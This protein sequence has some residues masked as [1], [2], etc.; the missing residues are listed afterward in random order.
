MISRTATLAVA[1]AIPLLLTVLPCQADEQE[2]AIEQC[3]DIDNPELR[4]RC[5]E[6]AI[7][8]LAGDR[9]PAPDTPAEVPAA[10][11][12]AAA[13]PE[14]TTPGPMAPSKDPF[15]I[16]AAAVDGAAKVAETTPVEKV[17]DADPPS[18]TETSKLDS[19]G[20]EQL[21][22]LETAETDASDIR[23]TAQVVAFDFVGRNKLRMRLQ[24][25]QVWRQIDADRG[26]FQAALRNKEH[27]EVELWQTSLGGYRMQ[28]LSTSKTV[29]VQRLK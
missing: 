6:D 14:S 7:R 12:T 11:E 17:T 23:V 24:N 10:A 2:S 20:S 9:A 22:G 29:R 4:I 21:P 15:G 16:E 5:L 26:D 13:A 25:G 8:Q 18:Q 28:I 27:F 3:S 1:S 19:M